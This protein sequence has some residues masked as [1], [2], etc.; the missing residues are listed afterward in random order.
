[1]DVDGLLERSVCFR[2]DAVRIDPDPV[3]VGQRSSISRNRSR[4][5]KQAAVIGGHYASGLYHDEFDPGQVQLYPRRRLFK[6]RHVQVVVERLVPDYKRQ[7]LVRSQAAGVE[8]LPL[9]PSLRPVP[10]D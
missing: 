4:S 2:Q 7:Y 9:A 5:G 10:A 6:D 1:E 8:S 3:N